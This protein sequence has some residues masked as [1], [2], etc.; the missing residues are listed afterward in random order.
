MHITNFFA[1]SFYIY[2]FYTVL[3][4]YFNIEIKKLDKIRRTEWYN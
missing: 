2:K 1:S 4:I 3:I